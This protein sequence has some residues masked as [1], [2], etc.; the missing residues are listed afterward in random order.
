MSKLEKYTYKEYMKISGILPYKT[1]HED[2]RYKFAS[3]FYYIN[4]DEVRANTE[5]F[6]KE[7]VL[8]IDEHMGEIRHELKN[9]GN[10]QNL[11]CIGYDSMH[12]YNM[13]KIKYDFIN[14]MMK[15]LEERTVSEDILVDLMQGNVRNMVNAYLFTDLKKAEQHNKEV[16]WNINLIYQ[17]MDDEDSEYIKEKHY[18]VYDSMAG[19]LMK[20]L[21]KF[22]PMYEKVMNNMKDIFIQ[23]L[24]DEVH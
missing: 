16:D 3:L 6:K 21:K 15:G 14:E 11:K 23:T 12:T 9:G 2:Y 13:Y 8:E 20:V 10:I 22:K 5:S 17:T 19:M 4:S 7:T 24:Y 18:S 1:K